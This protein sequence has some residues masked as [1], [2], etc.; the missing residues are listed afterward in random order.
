MKTITGICTGLLVLGLLCLS[1]IA[2]AQ[3]DYTQEQY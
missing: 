2:A 1:G 3:E